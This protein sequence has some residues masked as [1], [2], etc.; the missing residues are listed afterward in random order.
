MH[1]RKLWKVGSLHK[2]RRFWLRIRRRKL[3]PFAVVADCATPFFSGAPAAC[4]SLC[5]LVAGTLGLD[6]ARTHTRSVSSLKPSS[7][8]D[9][10]QSRVRQDDGRPRQGRRWNSQQGVWHH[11]RACYAALRSCRGQTLRGRAFAVNMSQRAAAGSLHS[12]V[13]CVLARVLRR[14]CSRAGG[15]PRGV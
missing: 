4:V 5:L 1:E 14:L 6:T 10:E 15:V 13:C 9:C 2:S 3:G 7:D 12:P 8:G 11:A